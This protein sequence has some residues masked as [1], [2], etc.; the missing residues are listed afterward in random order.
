[1]MGRTSI[2]GCLMSLGR[3]GGCEAVKDEAKGGKGGGRRQRP[4]IRGG[5][6]EKEKARG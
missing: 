4:A 2:D 6:L 3:S 1:M 5:N